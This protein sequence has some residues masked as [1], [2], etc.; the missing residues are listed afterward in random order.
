MQSVF[1]ALIAYVYCTFGLTSLCASKTWPCGISWMSINTPLSVPSFGQL[2][3]S[4]GA[5]CRA[6]GRTGKRLWNSSSLAPSSLG[7]RD[8]SGITGDNSARAA[9]R[10]VRRFPKTCATSSGTCGAPIP[11][12]GRLALWV[13]C[14]SWA[15]TWP[16]P[17]WRST[18]RKPSSPNYRTSHGTV[19]R[20]T[21]LRRV[22]L[23][24]GST[25][26]ATGPG[27]D[28]R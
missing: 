13:S 6:C 22:S 2:I 3:D 11:C 1:S 15:S 23:G 24:H 25:L 19:D 26:S 9:S 10:A 18:V 8:G 14:V 4:S 21:D 5:G 27:L 17:R 12:G 20:P 16:N 7:R 28:L